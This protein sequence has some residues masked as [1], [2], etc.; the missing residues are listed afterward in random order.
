M[1]SRAQRRAAQQAEQRRR[2]QR[3][4]LLRGI[5]ILALLVIG[6]LAYRTLTQESPGRAVPTLGNQHLASGETPHVLYN[7]RPP[8]SGPHLPSIAR[9]G[10]HTQPIP[11]ELQVHNLEDGGVLVQYNCRDC[12]AVIA[13][14][15]ATVSLYSDKVILAPYPKMDTRIA[16]TAWGRIDTFD[17][18]DEQR[19][20]RFIE[21]YRGIDHHPRQ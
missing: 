10:I 3:R 6:G 7:T 15:E 14:L 21:A 16:L 2:Q 12:D 13:Q 1:S 18:V 19:I 11:D 17:D 8:T 4:W 20:V 9:W 5:G